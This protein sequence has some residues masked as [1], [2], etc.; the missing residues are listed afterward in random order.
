MYTW[1][2][3]PIAITD[4]EKLA[5]AEDMQNPIVKDKIGLGFSFPN[6]DEALNNLPSIAD[7]KLDQSQSTKK[8]LNEAKAY[9]LV[10][11]NADEIKQVIVAYKGKS[12]LDAELP[13]LRQE[14]VL[15]NGTIKSPKK[16]SED[17]VTKIQEFMQSIP[18]QFNEVKGN[19]GKYPISQAIRTPNDQD[20][21]SDKTMDALSL[22]D[23]ILY[24]PMQDPCLC[25]LEDGTISKEFIDYNALI[26]QF[27]N[28][29]YRKKTEH[30]RQMMAIKA[31][32]RGELIKKIFVD[33]KTSELSQSRVLCADAIQ[34]RYHQKILSQ[35]IASAKIRQQAVSTYQ[36]N[37]ESNRKLKHEFVKAPN[38]DEEIINKVRNG[39]RKQWHKQLCDQLK[40]AAKNGDLEARFRL[41]KYF[42]EMKT[43]LNEQDSATYIRSSLVSQDLNK[44]KI[45]KQN[46][47]ELAA[48]SKVTDNKKNELLRGILADQKIRKTLQEY[49]SLPANRDLGKHLTKFLELAENESLCKEVVKNYQTN[50]S[51]INEQAKQAL[52]QTLCLQL[53]EFATHGVVQAQVLLARYFLEMRTDVLD[54]KTTISY[55]QSIFDATDSDNQN[56][57]KYTITRLM[58]A[59]D[60]KNEHKNRLREVVADQKIY[61]ILRKHIT[62]LPNDALKPKALEFLNLIKNKMPENIPKQPMNNIK[63]ESSDEHAKLKAAAEQGDIKAQILLVKYFCEMQTDVLNER[64][65]IAY[66]R[67]I[68]NTNNELSIEMPI[69][70]QIIKNYD[71]KDEK[72]KNRLL[73]ILGDQ[74]IRDNM[75]KDLNLGDNNATNKVMKFLKLAEQ[76]NP[77]D[78]SKEAEKNNNKEAMLEAEHAKLKVSAEGGNIGDKTRL[79]RYFCEMRTNVLDEQ[80]AINY[81]CSIFSSTDTTNQTII[82]GTI[83]NEMVKNYDNKNEQ[84]RNRLL[85]ILSDQ[86]IHETMHQYIAKIDHQDTKSKASEFLKLVDNKQPVTVSKEVEKNNEK[87]PIVAEPMTLPKSPVVSLPKNNLPTITNSKLNDQTTE[88]ENT[89]PYILQRNPATIFEGAP[90]NADKLTTSSELPGKEV[91]D[92]RQPDKVVNMQIGAADLKLQTENRNENIDKRTEI[93]PKNVQN[94]SIVEQQTSPLTTSVVPNQLHTMKIDPNSP[95]GQL[96]TR[97][98]RY[99]KR[100]ENPE[101]KLQIPKK[102]NFTYGFF[103][104]PCFKKSQAENREAN[105][106]LAKKFLDELKSLKKIKDIFFEI[107]RQRGDVIKQRVEENKFPNSYK[108]GNGRGIWSWE[109]LGIISYAKENFEKDKPSISPSTPTTQYK[110]S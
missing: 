87:K 39:M 56:V 30:P 42:L 24:T 3:I 55:I 23:P 80:K 94:W 12:W 47:L 20:K 35:K 22:N 60:I 34:T 54:V 61:N 38:A 25:L 53:K 6:L 40:T 17:N 29:N 5:I 36:N 85:Q 96:I 83:V 76:K 44:Q 84:Q 7:T 41:A 75:R 46:I 106:H 64:E 33:K 92:S 62:E 105:Y 37:I 67:S 45:I 74:K 104:L 93:S 82:K 99:I 58:V 49:I 70:Y 108:F 9:M 27:E 98:E 107:D 72:Q 52:H 81:I 43:D 14:D 63:K 1:S 88:I 69:I 91:A 109:L 77:V 57:I 16:A 86:Q 18:W 89:K 59:D 15:E 79:V 2:L 10:E 66:I 65:A 8:S 26:K 68:F 4:Q 48:D 97:L 11:H 31:I 50:C 101:N 110:L 28:T 13:E 90:N 102:P 21:I 71:S 19:D 103:C 100:I 73:G 51:G 78:T 95:R 32:F